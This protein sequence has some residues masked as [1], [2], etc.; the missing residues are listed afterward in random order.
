MNRA[1]ILQLQLFKTNCKAFSIF[2]LPQH[3]ID[4]IF[5]ES[6]F[7]TE[8]DDLVSNLPQS[9]TL[10]RKYRPNNMD[11]SGQCLKENSQNQVIGSNVKLYLL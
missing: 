9:A 8:K 5:L 2:N 6:E 11:L 4:C 7:R 10:F 3:K 1:N